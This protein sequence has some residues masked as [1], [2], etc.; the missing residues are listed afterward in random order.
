MNVKFEHDYQQK[1][2]FVSFPEPTVIRGDGDVMALRQAWLK[3]LSSWHSPYKALID[4]TN[5]KLEGDKEEL[6]DSFARMEKFLKGFF[7]KKAIL[8][9][10]SS[11]DMS[12]CIPFEY[13]LREEEALTGIGIRQRP[14]AEPTD[15]RSTIQIQ[16]H[17]AQHV[18]ELGFSTPVVVDSMEKITTLKSKI[19]NNLMQWHSKW[20]LLV[21]CSNFELDPAMAEEFQRMERFFKGFFLKQILGYSPKGPKESYPFVVYRARHNA[22][23]RLENEGKSSGD[24]ADCRSKK[25][26]P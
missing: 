15:F 8:W 26:T 22:A 11:S 25:A 4:G 12:I 18:M 17:F 21:D 24:Q 16:N 5:L 9:G 13:H 3:A 2:M 14:G 6:T 20:N 7:L 10:L 1:I 19:T 23:G